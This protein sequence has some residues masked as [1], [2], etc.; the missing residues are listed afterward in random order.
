MSIFRLKVDRLLLDRYATLVLYLSD[1]FEGGE[2]V[3]PRV[4]TPGSPG[5]VPS[6]SYTL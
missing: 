4:P 3:F 2:T 1:G 5:K 6:S